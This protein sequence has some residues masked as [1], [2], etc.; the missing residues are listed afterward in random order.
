MEPLLLIIIGISCGAIGGTLESS[1]KIKEPYGML[2][3][4]GL[5]IVIWLLLR[6]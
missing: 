1:K 4:L 5:V 3:G 2:I 6:K